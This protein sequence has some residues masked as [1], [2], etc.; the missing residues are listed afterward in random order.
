MEADI[1]KA[2][3]FVKKQKAKS[4][5]EPY[6]EIIFEMLKVGASQKTILEYL[7]TL[8]KVIKERKKETVASSL[9]KYIKT[10]RNQNMNVSNVIINTQKIT[11]SS[12]KEIKKVVSKD[13]VKTPKVT[14]KKEVKNDED[15]VVDTTPSLDK[16]FK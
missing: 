4:V 1:K 15:E 2:L 16:L 6:R 9:S 3:D 8:D 11:T 12:E 14:S 5:F 10:K 13:E 7:C